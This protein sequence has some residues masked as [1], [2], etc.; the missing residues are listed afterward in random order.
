MARD[1]LDPVETSEP[2]L[3]LAR[4]AV[5]PMLTVYGDQTPPRSRAEMEALANVEGMQRS[6]LP[7][8]KLSLHEEF[9]TDVAKVI[10]D[11]LARP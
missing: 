7:R 1:T 4:Q 11:F 3:A 9:A 6:R 2:F 8:G 5:I 10:A